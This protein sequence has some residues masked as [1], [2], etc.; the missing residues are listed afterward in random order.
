MAAALALGGCGLT[1]SVAR[2]EET[3][4][5]APQVVAADE[6][7]AV[8]GLLGV[9]DETLECIDG[10]LRGALAG[11]RLIR[12][13]EFRDAMFPWFEPE[14]A[15]TDTS[16]L[17]RYMVQPAVKQRVEDLR[18]HYVAVIEK[19]MIVKGSNWGGAIG[20]PGGA[21]IIGGVGESERTILTAH[22]LDLRQ[23]RRVGRIET[24]GE[25]SASIGLIVIIPYAYSVSSLKAACQSI[26]GRIAAYITGKPQA[27]PVGEPR[28]PE[29]EQAIG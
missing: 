21:V 8:A 22:I 11:M 27:P 1:G 20:G 7:I 5:A 3:R 25:G 18:V 10:E 26:A 2:V 12:P 16:S 28:P 17:S 14:L 29:P 9:D 23:F 15:P 13:R 19:A 24:E 6:A 4:H